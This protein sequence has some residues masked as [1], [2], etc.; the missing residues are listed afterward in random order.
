MI[1]S[2]EYGQYHSNGLPKLVFL[3]V[4]WTIKQFHDMMIACDFYDNVIELKKKLRDLFL[5]CALHLQLYMSN[6]VTHAQG[7]ESA[8][9]SYGDV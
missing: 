9:D 1:S 7:D 8:V 3:L 6:L 2:K 4:S 5:N